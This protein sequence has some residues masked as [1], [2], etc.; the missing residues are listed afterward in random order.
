VFSDVMF[1][2]QL[3]LNRWAEDE[4]TRDHQLCMI[5]HL[6]VCLLRKRFS[7]ALNF[8][9]LCCFL[10]SKK[11]KKYFIFWWY[12][13]LWQ[14]L[15]SKIYMCVLVKRVTHWM[16]LMMNFHFIYIFIDRKVFVWKIEDICLAEREATCIKK[17]LS[18]WRRQEFPKMSRIV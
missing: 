15:Q 14:I 7:A 5:V 11:L 13:E 2:V 3:M 1:V 6:L 8:A 12:C 17:M 4:K 9:C 16:M 10:A 18:D